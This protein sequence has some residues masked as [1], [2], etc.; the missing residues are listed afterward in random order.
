VILAAVGDTGYNIV[1]LL[2]I[3]TAFVAFAPAF[4]HP[5]I[6]EQSKQLGINGHRHV[7]GFLVQNGRRIYLPAL[8]VTGLLGF[9]LA[10]MSSD[11]YKLSQGWMIASIIVWIAINGLLH[12]VVSPGEGAVQSGDD[13][14]EARVAVGG[15]AVTVLF[16]VMLYLM[17]FKPGLG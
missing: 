13:S 14:A 3:L 12:A 8:I 16:L 4:V 17:V 9:A 2:H 1:L 15:M 10:G 7:Y 5:F 11:V 6:A